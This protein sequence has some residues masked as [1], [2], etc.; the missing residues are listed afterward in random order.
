MNLPFENHAG[1]EVVTVNDRF[2]YLEDTGHNQFKTVT[3]DAEYVLNDLSEEYGIRDKR[4]FYK[5]SFGQI[6]EILHKNGVFSGFKYGH[7]GYTLDIVLGKTPLPK[8]PKT[9]HRSKDDDFGM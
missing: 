9:K 7:S 8:K 2:I 6:D 5:D 4:I 3:N 1:Y